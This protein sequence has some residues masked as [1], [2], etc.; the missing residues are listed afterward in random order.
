MYL[1]IL[2]Y[3]EYMKI[4]WG[5]LISIMVSLSGIGGFWFYTSWAVYESRISLE[6]WDNSPHLDVKEA[7]GYWSITSGQS[8]D[9]H[10]VI[11]YPGGLVEAEAYGGLLAEVALRDNRDI[12]II[13][14][15]FHLSIFSI[16]RA[17]QVIEQ[18]QVT[19][20]LIGGHSLGGVAAC[21]FVK[22]NP[23]HSLFL[24]GSYCDKDISETDI[25]VISV[26]GN[27]DQI[28][29]RDNYQEAKT[30]LPPEALIY[31][32]PLLTHS[33]FG[34]YGLQ[35]GDAPRRLS[36]RYAIF[37]IRRSFHELETAQ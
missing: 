17:Q 9:R 2:L 23:Q 11:Y 4:F 1:I 20:A 22:N 32:I 25:Q 21:R 3:H 31:D 34:Q 5:V 6:K 28:I 33:D 12:Y 10:P 26:M 29:N 37:L 16:N 19:Q 30:H 8:S 13:Q 35:D 15:P 27:R 36:D 24:F 14:P 7:S 18:E